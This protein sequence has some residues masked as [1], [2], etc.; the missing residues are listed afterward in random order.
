MKALINPLET[1]IQYVSDWTSIPRPGDPTRV[2][3]TPVYGY[4]QNCNRVCDVVEQEFDVGPPLFWVDCANDVNNSEYYYDTVEQTIKLIPNK[5]R[6]EP[7]S[8]D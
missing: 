2:V 4:L 7:E 5:P 3:Y 8:I 1:Q 6:P